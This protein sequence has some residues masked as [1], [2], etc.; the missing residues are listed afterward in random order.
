MDLMVCVGSSC[1]LK[2]SKEVINKLKSLIAENELDVKVNLK[3]SFC[4]GKCGN[5]GVSVKVGDE[6]FSLK[7]EDVTDFFEKEIIAK[8]KQHKS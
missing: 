4:M 2:N 7:L 6:V 3:G 5:E 8:F 1:H